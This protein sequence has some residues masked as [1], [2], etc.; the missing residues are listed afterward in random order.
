MRTSSDIGVFNFDQLCGIAISRLGLSAPAFY[1]LSPAE[2]QY[3]LY[4]Q[5]QR[6]KM[7][8][9][10]Q[11]Q[12]MWEISR[13]NLLHF[14]RM[15]PYVKKKPKKA[16]EVFNLRWDRNMD[17]QQDVESMKK[18][19]MAIHESQK[20]KKPLAKRKRENKEGEDL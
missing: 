15:N 11:V 5:Q 1:E 19:L 18:V 13:N 17:Q 7:I 14:Y 2:Y 8:L 20:N 3:A 16:T 6:E 12:N 10:V 9:E 4:D